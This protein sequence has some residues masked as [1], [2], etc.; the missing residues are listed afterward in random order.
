[1]ARINPLELRK[2][3]RAA[4]MPEVKRLCK[5]YGR[6]NVAHCVAQLKEHEKGLAKLATLKR[7]VARLE[8]AL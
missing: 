3:Q 4:A 5:R 1:M 8:K 7:E 6:S 2:R